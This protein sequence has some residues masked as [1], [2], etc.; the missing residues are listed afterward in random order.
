MSEWTIKETK[1]L[2]SNWI[3]IV[4][5][6]NLCLLNLN[7]IAV[8]NITDSGKV[9]I[10]HNDGGIWTLDF[11]DEYDSLADFINSKKVNL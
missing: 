9:S 1:Y 3:E 10:Q 7:Q 2:K 5:D 4:T 11:D 8:I 6:G